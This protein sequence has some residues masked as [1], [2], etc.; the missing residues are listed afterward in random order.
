MRADELTEECLN[1]SHPGD[2][3]TPMQRLA[4]YVVEVVIPREHARVAADVMQNQQWL[5]AV[6]PSPCIW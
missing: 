4:R 3:L 6:P 1:N 5:S 2:T